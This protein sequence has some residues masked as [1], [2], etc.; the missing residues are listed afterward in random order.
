MMA[1]FTD[2]AR[3]AIRSAFGR[4]STAAPEV[5]LKLLRSQKHSL[6]ACLL[7]TTDDKVERHG[8]DGAAVG[9]MELVKLAAEEARARGK[10]YVG[11]EHVL[12]ALIR[13]S[14]DLLV[15]GGRAY[16]SLD[17]SLS[18]AEDEWA[19][20]RA[21]LARRLGIWCRRILLRVAGWFRIR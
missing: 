1:R 13:L 17:E 3:A 6:A 16:A 5:E 15:G 9:R 11:T 2:N 19:R 7:G 12:L 18:T 21:P 8:A 20:T 10:P 14:G 4:E